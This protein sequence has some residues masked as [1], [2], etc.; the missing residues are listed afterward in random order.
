MSMYMRCK[1]AYVCV[2]K[3]KLLIKGGPASSSR[4]CV[5]ADKTPGVNARARR[6]DSKTSALAISLY[7]A[8]LEQSIASAN[9][10]GRNKRH[11]LLAPRRR[12]A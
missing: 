11:G 2:A 10:T 5:P 4:T 3:Q 8:A 6:K 7:S 12:R 9:K 1:P